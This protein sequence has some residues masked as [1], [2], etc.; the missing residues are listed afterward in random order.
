[1]VVDLI[2]PVRMGT[3]TGLYSLF[4]TLSAIDGPKM[5]GIVQLAG[6]NYNAMMA[7]VQRDEEVKQVV[8]GN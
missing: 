4:S 6:N 8:P 2:E 1:M 3:F 7:G 5:R